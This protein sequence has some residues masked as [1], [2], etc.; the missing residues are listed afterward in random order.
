MMNDGRAR[1]EERSGKDEERREMEIVSA[2]YRMPNAECRAE[3]EEK[4]V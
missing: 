1:G 2:E 4:K 3:S